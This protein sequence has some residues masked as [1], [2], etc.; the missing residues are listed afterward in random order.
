M[1]NASKVLIL[2][3]VANRVADKIIEH[4]LYGDAD[5]MFDS[6]IFE[7]PVDDFAATALLLK[8]FRSATHAAAITTT[9]NGVK[10]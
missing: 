1:L 6:P 5:P 7:L 8:R 3:S 9:A 4:K 2:T 10:L